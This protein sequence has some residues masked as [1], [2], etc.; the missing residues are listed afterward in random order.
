LSHRIPTSAPV[1]LPLN[2]AGARI[3]EHV[4]REDGAVGIPLEQQ[5]PNRSRISN[6]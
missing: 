6:P 4:S 2:Q 5:R 3:V 1:S